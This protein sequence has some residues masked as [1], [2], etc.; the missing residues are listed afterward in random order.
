MDI[1]RPRFGFIDV[2]KFIRKPS[3]IMDFKEDFRKIDPW[4]Q[5]FD[6]FSQRYAT[7]WLFEVI[8]WR[9]DE[10]LFPVD[11]L[12][13]HVRVVVEIGCHLVVSLIKLSC[14][15][16]QL[17]VGILRSTQNATNLAAGHV[18]LFSVQHSDSWVGVSNSR[19]DKYFSPAECVPKQIK[20]TEGKCLAVDH[21]IFTE[22]IASPRASAARFVVH[23][24]ASRRSH[25]PASVAAWAELDG[26]YRR[27]QFSGA[28]VEHDFGPH[29]LIWTGLFEHEVARRLDSDRCPVKIL[30]GAQALFLVCLFRFIEDIVDKKT[31]DVEGIIMCGGLKH[32]RKCI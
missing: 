1:F 7:W 20:K 26:R 32:A 10:F 29:I 4:E 17:R 22:D 8:K 31:E 28:D 12:E 3:Q 27:S 19:R 23:A 24:A 13:A 9:N 14:E 21:A 5:G 16:F 15:G 25:H 18:P 30:E 2:A 11:H 6:G